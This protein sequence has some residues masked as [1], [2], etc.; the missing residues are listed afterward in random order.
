M[1]R[2]AWYE[3]KRI[4]AARVRWDGETTWHHNRRVLEDICAAIGIEPSEPYGKGTPY[5]SVLRTLVHWSDI[6][7]T[8]AVGVEGSP[9]VLVNGQLVQHWQLSMKAQ[10][11]ALRFAEHWANTG[12]DPLVLHYPEL[13]AD[14]LGDYRLIERDTHRIAEFV[15]RGLDRGLIQWSFYIAPGRS[16]E[17]CEMLL[18]GV[19]EEYIRATLGESQ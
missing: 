9:M 6:N 17:A 7:A 2:L 13:I 12:Y 16:A 18:D 3:Q 14:R 10:L 15:A 1:V 5:M 11:G 19:P 4:R 8:L